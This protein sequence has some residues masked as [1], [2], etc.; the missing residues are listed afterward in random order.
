MK[1]NLKFL[2]RILISVKAKDPTCFALFVLRCFNEVTGLYIDR[3]HL[4]TIML[5]TT[6]SF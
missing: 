3:L 4:K 1:Q 6:F 5:P 2:P